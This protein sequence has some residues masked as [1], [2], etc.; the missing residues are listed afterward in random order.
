MKTTKE[1]LNLFLDQ[2]PVEAKKSLG[3]NFLVSDIV[4]EKI[5]KAVQG[6]K[7]QT[8]IE[9]GPGPGALTDHLLEMKRP[10]TL[11]ELDRQIAQ[12]WR[13][14]QQNV[15]E[16][17]ALHWPWVEIPSVEETVLVSNLPYQI[18]SS[19]VIDRSMDAKP[20]KGMV[21]MF[22]KEVAQRIRALPSTDDY[23]MLSVIAQ[24]FWNITVVSEAGPRDFSPPPRVASRV[25]QFV[26]KSTDIM[27]RPKFLRFVKACFLQRRKQLKNN[28]SSLYDSQ[29]LTEA[30]HEWQKPAT[31]RAEELS[32]RELKDLYFRFQL[33]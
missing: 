28:L 20:L 12:H 15:V 26:P 16:V 14:Q 33:E 21:L 31:L 11:I 32:P 10:I 8:L 4:V 30:L 25:L 3:Q 24:N 23:G 17:D 6:L 2:L 27:E 29:R 19:L 22:Q 7:P 5:I 18:S 13:D 9:I 1:R